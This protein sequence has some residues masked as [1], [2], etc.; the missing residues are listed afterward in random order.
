MD[1]G[2]AGLG[3]HAAVPTHTTA[4]LREDQNTLRVMAVR[5]PVARPARRVAVAFGVLAVALAGLWIYLDW[6]WGRELGRQLGALCE[7]HAVVELA[8]GDETGV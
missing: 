4:F 3:F 8:E 7:A 6:Q 5:G 2:P 1:P